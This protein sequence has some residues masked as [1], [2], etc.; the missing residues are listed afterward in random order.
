VAKNPQGRFHVE[1]PKFGFGVRPQSPRSSISCPTCADAPDIDIWTK[2][3]KG[4][5]H[6]ELPKFGFGG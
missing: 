6:V 3:P 5:F 4:R 2:K 1:L